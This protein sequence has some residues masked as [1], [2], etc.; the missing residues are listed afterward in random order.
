[1]LPLTIPRTSVIV[2]PGRVS[3]VDVIIFF[4]LFFGFLRFNI[5]PLFDFVFFFV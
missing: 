1:V 2:F 5:F 4:M 3:V